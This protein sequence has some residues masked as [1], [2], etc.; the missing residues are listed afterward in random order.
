MELNLG[1]LQ[2]DKDLLS[3]NFDIP[4]LPLSELDLS[5]CLTQYNVSRLNKTIQIP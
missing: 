1:H 4:L 5:R 2:L 3:D